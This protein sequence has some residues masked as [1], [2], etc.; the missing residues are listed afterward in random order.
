MN[1]FNNRPSI[2]FVEQYIYPEGWSGAQISRDIINYFDDQGIRVQAICGTT[3]YQKPFNSE[4]YEVL[5]QGVNLIKE[6]TL[7]SNKNIFKNLLNQIL[8]CFKACLRILFIKKKIDCLII[9]TNPPLFLIFAALISFFKGIPL[10]VIA[11]DIYPEHLLASLKL[12]FFRKEFQKIFN[13]LFNIS[14][15]KASAV[16]SLGKSSTKILRRKGVSIQRIYEINNWATGNL[17][18]INHKDNYLYKTWN[19]PK[20]SF[21]ILYSGNLGYAHEYQTIT[22]A[23]KKLEKFNY[24]IKCLFVVSGRKV[25]LAKRYSSN[26]NLNHLISFHKILSPEMIPYSFSLSKLALVTIDE[27]YS[28]IVYPSKLYGYLARGLPVLYIGPKNDIS[29]LLLKHSCGFSFRNNDSQGISD[30]ISDLINNDKLINNYSLAAKECYE[31]NF[32]SQIGL[33]KY[34]SIVSKFL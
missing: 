26:L 20:Q 17:Q 2:L 24:K 25:D 33:K 31:E 32:S 23:I 16:I 14:Y 5:N 6:K 34:Y 30:L 29:E 28:G 18:R 19:L 27:N 11:M 1:Q 22:D 4:N 12:K 8:F 9:Q 15:K 10:V 7:K 3:F 21:N 13:F